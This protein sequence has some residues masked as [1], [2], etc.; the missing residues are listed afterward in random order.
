MSTA[1][2]PVK[3]DASH[4]SKQKQVGTAVFIEIDK[5]CAGTKQREYVVGMVGL[6]ARF[7]AKSGLLGGGRKSNAELRGRCGCTGDGFGRRVWPLLTVGQADWFSKLRLSELIEAIEMFPG[8][9][10]VAGKLVGARQAELCGDMKTVE[11][12][13][14]FV[15]RDGLVIAHE[16]RV[17]LAHEVQSIGVSGIN[18]RGPLKCFDCRVGLCRIPIENAEVVPGSRTIGLPAR[19]IQQYFLCLVKSLGVEQRNS[20][21]QAGGE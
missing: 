4:T 7:E 5:A 9:V 15:P 18:A 21:V 3:N 10:I 19:R 14:A 2:V 12:K 8:R 1:H 20:F 6:R 13:T 11:R 17:E 16:L